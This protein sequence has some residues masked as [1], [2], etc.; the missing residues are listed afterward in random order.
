[1][2]TAANATVSELH[3][4]MPVILDGEAWRLWLDPDLSDEA[5]D[6]AARACAR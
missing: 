5:V 2:T 4:R 6:V 3:N 1:M